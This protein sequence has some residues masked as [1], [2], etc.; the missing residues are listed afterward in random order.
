MF[1]HITFFQPNTD[2][3]AADSY[4]VITDKSECIVNL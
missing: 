4:V 2:I 1:M 3:L